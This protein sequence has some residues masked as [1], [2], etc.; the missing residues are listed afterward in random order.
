LDQLDQFRQGGVG[1]SAET[2]TWVYS[3]SEILVAP[4]AVEILRVDDPREA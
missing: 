1:S 4:P 3:F 2:A